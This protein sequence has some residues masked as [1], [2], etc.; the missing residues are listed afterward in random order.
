METATNLLYYLSQIKKSFSDTNKESN[1]FPEILKNLQNIEND[2]VDSNIK[3][4]LVE[5]DL[6]INFLETI[7]KGTIN[8]K[9]TIIILL[10]INLII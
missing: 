10:I 3:Q 2:F 5:Y 8:R 4:D 7:K 6:V 9:N 1:L